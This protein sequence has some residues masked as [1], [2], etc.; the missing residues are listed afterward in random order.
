MLRKTRC[1][2]GGRRGRRSDQRS[3]QARFAALPSILVDDAA[4][5]CLIDGRDHCLHVLRLPFCSSVRNAFLH[6]AQA[7][8][9]TSIAERAHSCLTS[10]FGGGFCVSHWET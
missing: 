8:Q 3:V 1:L 5:G 6:L 7:S 4:L 2:G 9:D 10:A